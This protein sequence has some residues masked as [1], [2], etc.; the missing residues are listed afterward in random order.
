MSYLLA[1]GLGLALVWALI[2]TVRA[3]AGGAERRTALAGVA[4]AQ[5]ER[6]A[7]AP[8]QEHTFRALAAIALRVDAAGR[9]A[10]I[11][12]GARERF[13]FLET[14]M[15]VLEAFSE[16]RLAERV[17][18][19]L[20]EL[21]QQRFEVRLFAAGRR[22]Y[23]ATVEPYLVVGQREALVV[24][25][26]VSEAVAYQ[27][28]RSQ[29]VANVSH[30]LR[31]PLT[32]L[33]TLLEALADPAMDADT[34]ARFAAR[35]IAETQRLTALIDDI[36]LLSELEATAGI[37]S[38]QGSDLADAVRAA[39][40][41]LAATAAERDVRLELD[42]VDAACPLG[43]RM[44]RTL[45]RNLLENAV[46]YAG[47]GATARATVTRGA[48][49]VRLTVA[50]D[51]P[52]I[53]E[54]HLPHIFERFYRADPSRSRSVGGTGLGLSI[55]KHISERHGGSVRAESRA[56]FGTTVTVTLPLPSQVNGR[57]ERPDPVTL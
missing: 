56:G 53:P 17:E 57:G 19:A 14:G 5:A 45:A 24:L 29:F 30:E 20:A 42:L 27:E 54:Q 36:L 7:I 28:L 23:H 26:D 51:G 46:R 41:E 1:A 22:S 3:R 37:A 12:P 11:G 44:A 18:R 35:G 34:S 31:T 43:E 16:H 2:A 25:T 32:G 38:G 10:Q 39:A 21:T 9:I 4:R 15:G 49:Q 40:G 52:G 48:D 6:A 55:V 47:P 50:D 33:R 8:R 13:P